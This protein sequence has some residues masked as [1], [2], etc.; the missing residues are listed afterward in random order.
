[1]TIYRGIKLADSVKL[2]NKDGSYNKKIKMSLDNFVDMLEYNGHCTLSEYIGNREKVLIDFKCHHDA[3]WTD[4]LTYKSGSSCPLCGRISMA[5]KQS[6]QAKEEL[7]ELLVQNNHTWIDGEYK[8]TCTKILIDFNCGHKPHWITPATYKS[9]TGTGCPKCCGLCP[10][11]AKEVLIK[12]IESNGHEWLEGE[13][14]NNTTK[15][16]IDFKCGHE[17]HWIQP[18][19]YKNGQSCPKCPKVNVLNHNSNQMRRAKEEL[20]E[21]VKNNKHK[22]LSEYNGAKDKVLIDFNCPHNSHW[23]TPHNYKCGN[24]CPIC[25]ESR[26]EKRVRKWLDEN[27]FTYEAQK[28]YDGLIGLGDGNLSYD[29]YIPKL[30]ILIEYQGEYHDGSV[31]NQT[32]EQFNIR[33]EHDRRKKE[34]ATLHNIEL[35]EIWYWDFDNVDSILELN[36]KNIFKQVI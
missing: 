12:L 31:R 32:E 25:G 16:C 23:I 7:I 36:C 35:L 18:N 3:H 17:P 24:G 19:N 2:H 14:K 1:L 21:L 22:L 33:Q 27:E 5:K 30:N 11:Q 20:I 13:Y 15:I 34:Y 28:E 10:E 26:G 29:F 6:K 4:P 9:G 8:N